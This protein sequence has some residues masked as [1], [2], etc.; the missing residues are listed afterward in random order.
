MKTTAFLFALCFGII[1]CSKNNSPATDPQPANNGPI[2]G[3]YSF[4]SA[5]AKAYDTIPGNGILTINEYTSTASNL[6]GS[7]A[8]TAS[9][10]TS[11]G[12][13]FDYTLVGTKKEVN[14]TN[15]TTVTT[16]YTPSSDSRGQAT[17]TYTSNYTINT[18]E[19]T[20]EDAQYLF[21]PA[22]LLQ[23]TNKKHS[24]ML[25]GNVLKIVSTFYDPSTRTRSVYEATFTK[26]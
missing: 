16:A 2:G 9:S 10:I 20:I 21:S 22:F 17:T 23:P 24:Y 5:E 11:K 8:I 4:T 7:L 19:L 26:Q 3:T 18:G 15:N 25:N 6:K 14:T 13:L 12:L 1:A